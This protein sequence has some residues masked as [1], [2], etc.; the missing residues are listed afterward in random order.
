MER[1][2]SSLFLLCFSYVYESHLTPFQTLFSAASRNTHTKKKNKTTNEKKIGHTVL[3]SNS[4]QKSVDWSWV[5]I[6]FT[7]FDTV[8]DVIDLNQRWTKQPFDD[9]LL[10]WICST[11]YWSV[12]QRKKTKG[13]I[14]TV[15]WKKRGRKK[16]MAENM[17][18]NSFHKSRKIWRDDHHLV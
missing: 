7:P 15:H 2:R 18:N 16:R 12:D 11:L 10:S 13:N 14:L 8:T 17:Q 3:I 9:M 4:N 6:R 5:Q 1:E